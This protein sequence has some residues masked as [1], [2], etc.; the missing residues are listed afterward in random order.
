MLMCKELG[1]ILMYIEDF[2]YVI[3]FFIIVLYFCL[4]YFCI[5]KCDFILSF[6]YWKLWMMKIEKILVFFEFDC[7]L[8]FILLSIRFY[9]FCC[10]VDL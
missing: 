9:R 7:I 2:L 8:S 4:Y 6:I 10:R 5:L 1:G 3:V